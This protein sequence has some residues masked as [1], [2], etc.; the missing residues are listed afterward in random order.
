[1]VADYET[2]N[3]ISD[4]LLLREQIDREYR[5]LCAQEAARQRFDEEKARS[6]EGN[7][8]Q[9]IKW[10][11][12]MARD[13]SKVE[14]VA[15]KLMAHGQQMALVGDGKAGKSLLCLEWAW[16]AAA[17]LPFLGDCAR[18]PI[19]VLYV[20][21]ENTL[22]DIQSRLAA[23]GATPEEL[24]MLTYLPFPVFRPLN[25]PGGGADLLRA[26]E[27]HEAQLVFLDTISRMIEGKE[28]DSDPWLDLYR[29][30]LLPLKASGCGSVR[31]D[32]FGKDKERGS[33]GS[34]AKTQDVDQVWE[35]RAESSGLLALKRTHT[36][37]GVGDGFMALQRQGKQ[38]DGGWAPG[39][40]RHVVTAKDAD[41]ARVDAAAGEVVKA[42]ADILAKGNVPVSWGR[43]KVGK[44]L[45][46]EGY[47]HADSIVRDVVKYRQENPF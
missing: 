41:A 47:R 39:M 37:S 14:W 7:R 28:N 43:P 25:T 19:R 31:L 33:R 44:W 29:H 9:P 26:I 11:E 6:T 21:Q 32:H 23:L 24:E 36:R 40:T 27:R 1:M 38:V 15:G 13:L 20:D 5:R 42:L 22:D 45:R 35:L 16:R 46:D 2:R 3:G 18:D 10:A 34:S 8:A 17:G 12:F 4:E 30:T